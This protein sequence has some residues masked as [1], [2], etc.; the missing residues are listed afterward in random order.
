MNTSKPISTI[1]YNSPDFLR[2]RLDEYRRSGVLSFWTFIKHLG[3]NDEA[4]LKDH[5]HV[6]A[7]PA[8]RFQTDSLDFMEP[9]AMKPDKPLN[10][11]CWR[12]SSFPDWFL[13]VIHDTNYLSQK[14]LVKK[15]H[16]DLGAFVS[17]SDEDFTFLSRSVD[18]LSVSPYHNMLDAIERGYTWQEY[19]R[20][21][22]IPIQLLRQYQ[23]AWNIL[24]NAAN[25]V[26]EIDADIKPE[27]FRINNL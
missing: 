16:Y 6:Y 19:V 9:D 10:C 3:E 22:C 17:S 27:D 4:G 1:S 15:Y 24:Q 18:R 21:G 8:K 12:S 25:L 7:E 5:L 26:P 13:Y 23:I 11:I 14:G 20:R 2:L